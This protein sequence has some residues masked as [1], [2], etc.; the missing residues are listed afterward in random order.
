[1]HDPQTSGG[2]LAAVP[3]GQVDAFMAYCSEHGQEAWVIGDVVEGE[4]VE[5]V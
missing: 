2:L 5:I 3:A 4:G 1:L